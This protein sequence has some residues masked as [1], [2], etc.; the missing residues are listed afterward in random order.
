MFVRSLIGRISAL[1]G[2]GL[3][4]LA[5]ACTVHQ[6]V[7]ACSSC[8]CNS[9]TATI[10]GQAYTCSQVPR[11]IDAPV[12]Y[13]SSLGISCTNTALCTCDDDEEEPCA[14]MNMGFNSCSCLGL[15]T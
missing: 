12:T 13:C 3:L 9:T 7:F 10:N 5:I 15:G 14:C 11:P 1:A 8:T 6:N 4:V 2:S